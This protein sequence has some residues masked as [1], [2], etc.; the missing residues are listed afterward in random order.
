MKKFELLLNSDEVEVLYTMLADFVEK[1]EDDYYE[2]EHKLFD[3]VSK[4]QAEIDAAYVASIEAD[5]SHLMYEY[6]KL[7]Q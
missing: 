2:L 7:T 3:K 1:H 6:F 5:K 4:A